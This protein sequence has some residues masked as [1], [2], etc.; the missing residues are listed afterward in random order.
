MELLDL[1]NKERELT[2][3]KISRGVKIPKGYYRL[4]VHICIFNKDGKMLIQKRNPNKKW[5]NKWDISVGGCVS[6]G[7]TSA[8]AAKR[9]LEEELGIKM[10][11][12]NTRCNFTFHFDEG[13]DDVFL[14]NVDDLDLSKL[15]LQETEVID[16]SWA[17]EEK[18]LEMIKNNEFIEYYSSY[19]K[20]LFE[21]RN[22]IDMYSEK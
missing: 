14:I 9:E 13:F 3:L 7:E 22:A 8:V 4:V 6:S 20:L 1:Y 11:L 5:G 17:S 18:I 10:D 2:D 21:F 15:K 16:V 19:I 12:T